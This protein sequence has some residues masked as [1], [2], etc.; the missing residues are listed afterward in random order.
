MVDTCA[1]TAQNSCFR[2]CPPQK[3]WLLCFQLC[4]MPLPHAHS[5]LF[6][7]HWRGKEIKRRQGVQTRTQE[8]RTRQYKQCLVLWCSAHITSFHDVNPYQLAQ[9]SVNQTNDNFL[10]VI[11]HIL[12]LMRKILNETSPLRLTLWHGQSQPIKAL[13]ETVRAC[14]H[15]QW[16]HATLRIIDSGRASHLPGI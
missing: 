12:A 5:L 7:L 9:P 1:P 8:K 16:K 4:V 6:T 3:D 2:A 14:C 15:T 13:H 10:K 11:A